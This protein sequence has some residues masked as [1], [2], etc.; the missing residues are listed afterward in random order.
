MTR[1]EAAA[2]ILQR[3]DADQKANITDYCIGEAA[4]KKVLEQFKVN[5]PIP[6]SA[7]S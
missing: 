3:I 7:P 4:I 1:D 6:E 5:A 2:E